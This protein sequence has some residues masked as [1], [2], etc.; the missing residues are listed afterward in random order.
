MLPGPEIELKD[1]PDDPVQQESGLFVFL[2]LNSSLNISGLNIVN[3]R[4]ISAS[5]KNCTRN[6]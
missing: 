1:V 2:F 4:T 3:K 6:I 5:V